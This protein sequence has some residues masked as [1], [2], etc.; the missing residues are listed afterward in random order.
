VVPVY[1]YQEKTADD[2]IGTFGCPQVQAGDDYYW[3]RPQTFTKYDATYTDV[4]RAP[5]AKAYGLNKTQEAAL[6]FGDIYDYCDALVCEKF[7]GLPDR[8]EMTPEHW[9]KCQEIQKVDLTST[10]DENIRP[11]YMARILDEPLKQM[12]QMTDKTPSAT[13]IKYTLYSAHDYQIANMLMYLLPSNIDWY[14]VPYASN[15]QLELV[16]D[17]S[18]AFMVNSYYNGKKMGFEACVDAKDPSPL[19]CSYEE[20]VGLMKQLEPQGEIEELCQEPF[21]PVPGH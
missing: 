5:V 19:N 20:F 9:H 1:N 17:A 15:I 10:M 16:S 11:I 4:L 6:T 7:E 12:A 13:D 2:R 8:V 3:H 21:V 14:M 18:G